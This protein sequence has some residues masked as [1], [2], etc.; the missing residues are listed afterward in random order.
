MIT[1]EQEHQIEL[2]LNSKKLTAQILAEV[3][4]HFI[5][6]ISHLMLSENLSFPEAFLKTKISWKN[7]LEMVN[8]DFLSF[9]KV[10]RIEKVILQQRF[11]K[12]GIFSFILAT[13]ATFIMFLNTDVFFTVQ[14][15]L[16]GSL[17][18]LLAYSFIAKKMKFSNYIA[19]SFHPLLL[20]NLL[21]GV[22]IFAFGSFITAE[23]WKIMDMNVSKFLS[24]YSL[25]VQLQLLYFN[26]KKINVLV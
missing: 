2:Y 16:L 11:R 15:V 13:V 19:M 8:A 18:I 5:S 21:F 6:Q 23:N 7:E 10:A 9:K 20:R 25:A 22:L 24:V 12:I 14:I 3:K 4:D 17:A 1:K 26:S